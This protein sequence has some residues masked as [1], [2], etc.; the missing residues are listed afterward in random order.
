[1]NIKKF[2][3][4]YLLLT[5]ILIGSCELTSSF[6]SSIDS[7]E[8]SSSIASYPAYFK[9][10]GYKILSDIYKG[11]MPSTGDVNV[12]VIPIDFYDYPRENVTVSLMDLHLTFFGKDDEVEWESVS[13][14]YYKSSYGKLNISG[15]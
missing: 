7:N 4:I 1:M 11:V 2:N 10:E 5:I 12:L 9:P 15:Q 6:T 8:S 14:Y 13:S 3:F